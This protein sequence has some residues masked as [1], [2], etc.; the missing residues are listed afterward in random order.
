[1]GEDEH[2]VLVVGF[3]EARYSLRPLPQASD[4]YTAT[5]LRG[6]RQIGASPT[7][8]HGYY[9]HADTLWKL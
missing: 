9:R 5:Q 8:A 1:M 6:T 7:V 3:S 4:L 2:S